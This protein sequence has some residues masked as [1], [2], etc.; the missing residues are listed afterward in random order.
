MSTITLRKGLLCC[1]VL[2]MLGAAWGDVRLANLFGDN[3]V[4]QR[5][6]PI[7]IWG[8]AEAG[9]AVTV[10]LGTTEAKTVADAKGAWSVQLP[11]LHEGE[12]LTLTAAGKNTLT[13]KNLIMGDVWICGG[14]SNMEY[15]VGN[16]S[17][18]KPEIAAADF[19]KIRHIRTESRG[20]GTPIDRLQS[21]SPEE[22][23]PRHY[24]WEVC[25]PQTAGRFTAAGYYFAREIFQQTGIPIGLICVNWGG[26]QIEPWTPQIGLN[27]V[28]EMGY[29]RK[30]LE[31]GMAAYH[32][33]FPVYVTQMKAWMKAADQAIAAGQPIPRQP[34]PP[35]HPV[36]AKGDGVRPFS[37]YN[38]M[39]HPWTRF[40]IKGALWYQ[41]EANVGDDDIYYHK[42]RALVG[43]WRA[44]WGQGEFPFY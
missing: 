44:A 8:W 31:D 19:P 43:G 10:T 32:Q 21:G 28:P 2:L 20:A 16:F 14:Q 22:D 3:M 39:I 1:C 15:A 12:G 4:L 25:S 29:L 24:D 38:A 7:A 13:L 6:R 27:G 35:A 33:Q 17:D 40:P 36:W 41:G 34:V 23:L 11:A 30:A 26:T 37:L 18:A 42:M 5:D 9:E